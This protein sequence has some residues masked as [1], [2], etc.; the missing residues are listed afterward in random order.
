MH[1]AVYTHPKVKAVEF[2]ICDA[3]VA[4]NPLFNYSE[5]I[6]TVE[7]FLSMDDT[8]IKQIETW[9][10][11][12][13]FMNKKVNTGFMK[14]EVELEDDQEA[15]L[16]K[17]RI[18]KEKAAG[19]ADLHTLATRVSLLPSSVASDGA[20]SIVTWASKRFPSSSSR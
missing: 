3:L 9:K 4:A 6:K 15:A 14:Q 17:V 10:V 7:G 16:Q 20:R 18:K 12:T 2:L 13:G 5:R 8:I 19:G 11:N 1:R